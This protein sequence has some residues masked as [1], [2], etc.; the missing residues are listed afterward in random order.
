[1]NKLFLLISLL[2]LFSCKNNKEL[3][4]EIAIVYNNG[5]LDTIKIKDKINMFYLERGDLH[6]HYKKFT[7]SSITLLSNVR[8][9]KIIKKYE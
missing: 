6:V 3:N 7:N 1:M 5:D 8:K 2:F 4:Y 9:Y